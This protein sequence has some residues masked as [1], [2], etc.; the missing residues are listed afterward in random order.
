MSRAYEIFELSCQKWPQ[1]GAE[2]RRAGG[3]A[4]FN[5]TLRMRRSQRTRPFV[6]A[7]C[8]FMAV[9]SALSLRAFE[10]VW[11]QLKHG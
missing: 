4:L 10:R 3:R 2:R 6:G 7:S 8:S 1:G 5:V 9:H 11:E